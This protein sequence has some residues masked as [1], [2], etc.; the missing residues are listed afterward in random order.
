[1]NKEN[2]YICG[3]SDLH[4]NLPETKS[5]DIVVICGDIFPLDIQTNMQK[6][7]DWLLGDFKNWAEQLPCEKVILIAGNHDFYLGRFGKFIANNDIARISSKIIYLQDSSAY[8]MGVHFYGCPWCTG[9]LGWAFCPDKD[10]SDVGVKYNMIPECDILLTHQPAK[11]GYLGTSYPED[12][13]RERDF[14][15]DRLR[16][17][18]Y[19]KNIAANFCGHIHSGQHD[20]VQYPVTGCNTVFYNVSLLDES[21]DMTY[22]PTYVRYNIPS[23]TVE[24]VKSVY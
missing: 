22:K 10:V 7:E 5:C 13:V 1:M 4:G 19:G 8:V 21:Y 15:S 2:I 16:K 24:T 12:M 18:I 23:R 11:I 6:C 14:G 9:P 17:A 20:G 3:I